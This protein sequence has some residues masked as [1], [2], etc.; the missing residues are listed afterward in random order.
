[1]ALCY[2][3]IKY[4]ILFSNDVVILLISKRSFELKNM[5]NKFKKYYFK[6]NEIKKSLTDFDCIKNKSTNNINWFLLKS[7]IK[8]MNI[9]WDLVSKYKIMN[10]IFLKVFKHKIDWPLLSI[11]NTQ[12]FSNKYVIHEFQNNIDW[13]MATAFQNVKYIIDSGL[14]KYI[15]KETVHLN[16]YQQNQVYL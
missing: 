13:Y 12:T 15:C 11:W 16:I 8:K 6:K 2:D 5:I 1:M 7:K 4:I 3:L 14:E 9:K 10:I